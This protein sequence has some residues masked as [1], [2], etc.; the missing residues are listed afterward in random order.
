M[1]RCRR[2]GSAYSP[3]TITNSTR[4]SSQ[5]RPKLASNARSLLSVFRRGNTTVED[6]A[7]EYKD[8]ELLIDVGREL[9]EA[10][11]RRAER[12]RGRHRQVQDDL[13]DPNRADLLRSAEDVEQ[14]QERPRKR[15]RTLSR[16]GSSSGRQEHE[17]FRWPSPRR[18]EVMRVGRIG[19][20]RSPLG[21]RRNTAP[22]VRNF[23]EAQG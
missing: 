9:V 19:G 7:W 12:R 20:V 21:E 13:R 17:V 23:R 2:N 15:C 1:A 6:I 4:R 11:G 14:L 16:P 8:L 3:L 5:P 22:A 18:R 10:K